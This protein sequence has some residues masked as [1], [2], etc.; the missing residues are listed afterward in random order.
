MSEVKE[1]ASEAKQRISAGA[2]KVGDWIK[3][4]AST[5]KDGVVSGYDYLK[6]K[7]KTNKDGAEQTLN[8]D[9]RTLDHEAETFTRPKRYAGKH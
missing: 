6:K 7:I 1:V 9:M 3:K 4:K 2:S 5:V 8:Q